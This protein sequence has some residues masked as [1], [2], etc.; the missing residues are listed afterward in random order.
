[1]WQGSIVAVQARLVPRFLWTTASIEV[2]LERQC[3]L[4]TGGQF[5]FVG[6]QSATFTHAGSTHVAELSWD[7]SRSF[8]L[9]SLP[10][11]LRIDGVAVAAGP[12]RIHNWPVGLAAAILLAALFATLFQLVFATRVG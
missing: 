6:S 5:K 12:A 9:F 2:S 3:I 11:R 4:R 10:Y 1:M 7:A 8:S